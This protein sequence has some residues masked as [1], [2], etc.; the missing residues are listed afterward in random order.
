M[1]NKAGHGFWRVLGFG[2]LRE[3]VHQMG[4]NS[5]PVWIME[6]LI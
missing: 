2:D 4:E 5:A 6:R 1:D 3:D